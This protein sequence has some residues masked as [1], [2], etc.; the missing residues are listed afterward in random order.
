MRRT[1]AVGAALGALVVGFVA[2]G[3]VAAWAA[4]RRALGTADG[5]APSGRGRRSTG[6]QA[7]VVLGYRNPSERINAVNRFRVRA[8]VRT[9]DPAASSSVLVLCGGAVA[10]LVP[11]AELLRRFARDELG[12]TGPIRLDVTST[13]TWENIVAA[14]PLIEDAETIAIVSNS[15]HAQKARLHLYRLR[16]DLADRLVRGAD[17][18]LGEIPWIKPV[19]AVLGLRSLRR[20]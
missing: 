7:V 17:Y 6:R 10:G 4:S 8:G 14:I 20:M 11:E 12:F 19:E 16:P 1:W 2:F 18:R 9:L 3:E 5:G 15:H 13:S